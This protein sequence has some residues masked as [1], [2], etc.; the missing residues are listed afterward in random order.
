MDDLFCCSVGVAF[1][2]FLTIPHKRKAVEIFGRRSIEG[3][4]R[5]RFLVFRYGNLRCLLDRRHYQLGKIH[6]IFQNMGSF[7]TY[8]IDF[9]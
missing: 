7:Y 6:L 3:A 2:L 8:H 1:F 4:L 9:I 5:R